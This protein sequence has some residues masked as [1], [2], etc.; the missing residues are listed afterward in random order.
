MTLWDHIKSDYRAN[1]HHW[2]GRFIL[3]LY[4]LAHACMGAPVWLKPFC[5]LYVAFYKVFMEL[6]VGTEIHWKA[7]IGSGARV[8]H[9]FGLVVH[10][11]AVIGDNVI[12]R[13]GV[14]IGEKIVDG[15]VCVP[16]IGD[17]VDIGA[18][19]LILGNVKVGNNA[20]IGAG[21]IVVKDVPEN[22]VVAGNPARI[23]RIQ[24]EKPDD[25]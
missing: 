13:Q 3:I 24:D 20:I 17:N 6:F 18:S 25:R 21:S 2:K 14:T 1:K 11:K 23:I 19:A 22:A 8:H 10:Y 5:F 15:A 4:R 12:L 16:V 7:S 9:G